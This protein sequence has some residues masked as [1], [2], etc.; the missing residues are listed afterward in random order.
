MVRV[1]I[2]FP[3][4]ELTVYPE[5]SKPID[6]GV[7]FGIRHQPAG[8]RLLVA[9]VGRQ[10]RAEAARP[11]HPEAAALG[12]LDPAQALR[13]ALPSRHESEDLRRTEIEE[14]SPRA[15]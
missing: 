14:P 5:P 1:F 2:F 10:R 15:V 13:R 8:L 9:D 7:A 12:D 11:D 6:S 4:S 3:L